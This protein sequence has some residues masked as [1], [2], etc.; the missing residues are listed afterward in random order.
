[1]GKKFTIDEF[2]ITFN[3]PSLPKGLSS[4]KKDELET[5]VEAKNNQNFEAG[6]KE[7]Y[8]DHPDYYVDLL[9]YKL[10]KHYDAG[11]RSMWLD[12]SPQEAV[13]K[14][15]DKLFAKGLDDTELEKALED[16]SENFQVKNYLL[17]KYPDKTKELLTTK[18]GKVPDEER[19][20]FIRNTPME[21]QQEWCKEG[22]EKK[23]RDLAR[24]GAVA[25]LM[26]PKDKQREIA[27]DDPEF[28]VDTLVYEYKKNDNAADLFKDKA[29]LAVIAKDA[30]AWKK[31]VDST[32]VL[33]LSEAAKKRVGK[34]NPT[35]AEM[36]NALFQSL[37]EN[38]GIELTYFTMTLDQDRAVLT[39][40]N[41]ND[42]KNRTEQSQKMGVDVPDKPA[43]Q[44]HNL[45]GV[46]K[47]VVQNNVTGAVITEDSI[48]G[49]LLT[50]PLS[51]MPGGL[52]PN[53]FGGN[54]RDDEGKLTGQIMFTGVGGT[55]SHTWLIIDGVPFDPVLGTKG[56]QVANSVAEE[57]TWKVPE[58]IGKG[59]NGN[60]IIKDPALKPAP[61]SHGFRPC[62]RLTKKPD[63]YLSGLVGVTFIVDTG[64]VK[65]D[66]V[67]QNGPANNLLMK[68]DIVL[69]VDGADA[70]Q[71]KLDDY[72]RANA[73]TTR[74]FVIR[75]DGKKKKIKVTAASAMSF[76]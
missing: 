53:T 58:I 64:E 76:G 41:D 3:K 49:M 40:M 46:M 11:K 13:H 69:K 20:N 65:V 62:Y 6:A 35:K 29:L 1:V 10:A 48:K 31:L 4:K 59:N 37:C 56:D 61:N 8:K 18:L 45:K 22:Y 51:G 50:K 54:V 9:S 27:D 75:R 26:L 34:D 67:V 38:D 23:N 7:M 28:F 17:Q 5:A 36:T 39:G 71:T 47:Q 44:C 43:T 52:L 33:S 60:Y 16:Y 25:L 66:E 21:V 19:L 24:A 32:P 30:K 70:D 73:G 68:K 15:L 72:S 63:D 74:V 42:Q 55:Q 14:V 57:F 2:K 12:R